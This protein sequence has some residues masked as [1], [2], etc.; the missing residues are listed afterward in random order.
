MGH[1]SAL[2]AMYDLEEVAIMSVCFGYDDNNMTIVVWAYMWVQTYE[3]H[4]GIVRPNG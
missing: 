2:A 3:A 1:Q 4:V